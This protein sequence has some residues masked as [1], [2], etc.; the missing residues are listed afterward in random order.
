[1]VFDVTLSSPLPRPSTF[2]RFHPSPVSAPLFSETLLH[3]SLLLHL[4]DVGLVCLPHLADAGWYRGP[5]R[6]LTVLP[7]PAGRAAARPTRRVSLH[8][9]G[10]VAGAGTGA[11]AGVG[12]RHCCIP[13][14]RPITLLPSARPEHDISC[15]G[16]PLCSTSSPPGSNQR[17]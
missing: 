9:T 7:L 8:C 11:G 14:R 3:L 6:S 12:A 17:P 10:A 2:P 15:P 1:M 4:G 5:G 13:R 16:E